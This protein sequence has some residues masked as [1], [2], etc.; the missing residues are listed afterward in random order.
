VRGIV[1]VEMVDD[2]L[3]KLTDELLGRLRSP[4]DA[5]EAASAADF[6]RRY[7]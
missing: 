4:L 2:V 5:A 3:L 7:L 1:A 6:R